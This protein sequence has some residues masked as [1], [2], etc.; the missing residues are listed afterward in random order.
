[1]LSELPGKGR[2]RLL[3]YVFLCALFAAAGFAGVTI[4]RTDRSSNKKPQ[5]IMWQSAAA[6]PHPVVAPVAS[7]V[8]AQGVSG[9]G[10]GSRQNTDDRGSAQFL[11]HSAPGEASAGNGRDV[12][13]DFYIKHLALTGAKG[14]AVHLEQ[15]LPGF[16]SGQ[17]SGSGF[18]QTLPSMHADTSGEHE[19]PREIIVYGIT[20]VLDT[21]ITIPDGWECAAITSEGV[22]KKGDKLGSETV[23]AVNKT[24]LATGRRT[25]NFN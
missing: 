14:P 13:R 19:Q 8:P 3:F 24:S 6:Q 21:G 22:L 2:Q 18:M 16:P 15:N 5:S 7:P 10:P 23:F 20:C 17:L 4:M 12:F 9:A 1:M 11:K 25:V